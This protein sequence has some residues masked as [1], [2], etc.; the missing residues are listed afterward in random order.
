M[1]DTE[2][3]NAIQKLMDG[4]EWNADTLDDIADIVRSTSRPVED[5]E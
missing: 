2:A 5:V 3:M 1:N 4:R